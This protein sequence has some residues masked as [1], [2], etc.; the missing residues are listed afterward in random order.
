MEVIVLYSEAF[1]A[2]K[3]EIK[4]LVKQAI[5]ELLEEKKSEAESDWIPLPDAKKLLPLKSK[6]SW[7]KI[8]ADG[9]INFTQFGRKLMY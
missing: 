4:G 7:Q 6:T 8:R 5:A 1:K 3:Q 2:L 9:E